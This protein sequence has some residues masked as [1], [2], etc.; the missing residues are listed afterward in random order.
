MSENN[1]PLVIS[2]FMSKGGVTKT[3]Q[4]ALL[5]QFFAGLGYTTVVIDW[6]QQ[7]SQ[8]TAFDLP[9]SG[10]VLHQVITNSLPP[11]M[12]IR[13]VLT[14]VDSER[15]IPRFKGYDPGQ[16][17]VAQ[18]GSDTAIAIDQVIASPAKFG[19]ASNLQILQRP[20]RDLAG[21]ADIV[22][23]DMGP[24]DQRAVIGA[25]AVTDYV[26]IPTTLDELSVRQLIPT[27]QLIAVT[28][29][30]VNP[31]LDV[32]GI[33]PVL[34]R[35]FFGGLRASNN[36]QVGREFL[37]ENH[38]SLLLRSG[39]EPV[40]IEDREDWR[41]AVRLGYSIFNT[42]FPSKKVQ[43]EA[44]RYLNAVAKRLGLDDVHLDAKAVLEVER[45]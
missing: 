35:T 25:L 29:E 10:E 38:D 9:A 4:A 39:N 11:G 33:L 28:R 27:L 18:G 23:L 30:A 14:P 22:I 20:I 13:D 6:D 19:M 1:K 15:Y 16:L 2:V 41:D 24:S 43:N 3:T 42:P 17:F 34:T 40:E 32:L 45:E 21:F 37:T 7:G 26:L 8:T 36:T 5:A 12:T 31:S 44:L